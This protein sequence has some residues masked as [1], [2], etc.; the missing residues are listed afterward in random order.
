MRTWL[1]TDPATGVHYLPGA[2][3]SPASKAR[4]LRIYQLV[5]VL[6]D[7]DL[8]RRLRVRGEARGVDGLPDLQ[9]ALHLVEG[10][11]FEGQR[12]GGWAWLADGVRVDHHLVCGIV[13]VAHLVTMAALHAGDVTAARTATEIAILAAPYED[14]PQLDL[15]AIIAAEGDRNAA[16]RVLRDKV[17]NRSGRRGSP[18]R[19]EPAHSTHRRQPDLAQLRRTGGLTTKTAT[20]GRGVRPLNRCPGTLKCRSSRQRRLRALLPRRLTSNN[21]HSPVSGVSSRL[22][23]VDSPLPEWPTTNR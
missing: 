22:N 20:E 13:D 6:V 17:S 19:P 1:G 9:R 23:G 11:P 5:G 2:S 16:Q 15:A 21:S 10:E 4:G 18:R 12:G 7:L 3:H 14:T 8:F